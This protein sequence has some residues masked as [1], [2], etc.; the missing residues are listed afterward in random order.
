MGSHVQM[1]LQSFVKDPDVREMFMRYYGFRDGDPATLKIL[2]KQYGMSAEGV[3]LRMQRVR[4][5]LKNDPRVL[6]LLNPF[7]YGASAC[8]ASRKSLAPY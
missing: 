1:I 3:R 8:E 5:A 4:V 7:L 6:E 2:A